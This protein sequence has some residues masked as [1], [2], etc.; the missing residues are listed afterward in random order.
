MA[1]H[2][3]RH[4]SNDGAL[5]YVG[6]SLSTLNRLS[7]HK[8][9]SHWF[10]N[11][12][13]VEIESFE[14]REEAVAAERNAI[15]TENPAHNIIRYNVKP[16]KKELAEKRVEESREALVHRIVTMRPMYC[17][18]E[19][20]SILGVSNFQIKEW[21]DAGKLASVMVKKK[22]REHRLITGWQL[23]DFIEYLQDEAKK[24]A[25]SAP[26]LRQIARNPHG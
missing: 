25:L 11:I 19:A 21:L 10:S 16:T 20:R 17:I 18:Q 6:I 5:L 13:R 2:L 14:T 22:T 3:Y 8:E 15:A 26:D 1:H 12:K 23:I 24:A 9:N 4:F 7:Q